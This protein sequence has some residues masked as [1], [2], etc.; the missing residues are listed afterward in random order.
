MFWPD[1]DYKKVRKIR[2]LECAVIIAY[3]NAEIAKKKWV[4]SKLRVSC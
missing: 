3:L 2:I 1:I 4:N